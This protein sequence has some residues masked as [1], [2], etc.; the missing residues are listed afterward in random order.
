MSTKLL[1]NSVKSKC[2]LTYIIMESHEKKLI[3]KE[4]TATR[5]HL[6]LWLYTPVH[7]SL[8]IVIKLV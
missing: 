5:T 4:H 6:I 2:I 7:N 8:K 3:T 1:V